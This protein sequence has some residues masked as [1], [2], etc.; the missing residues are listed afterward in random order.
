MRFH[1]RRCHPFV[2]LSKSA[3]PT[4]GDQIYAV[5]RM[6]KFFDHAL[7]VNEGRLGGATKKPRTL[8]IPSGLQGDLGMP[9]FTADGKVIGI[10]VLQIPSKEDVEGGD[11]TEMMGGGMSV[12]ILP[13]DEVVK[14]TKRSKEI[15]AKSDA[16][17]DKKPD[18]SKPAANGETK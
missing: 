13:A 16:A 15:A 1:L 14:A 8:L 9:M 10:G 4:V 2:D 18:E 6:A 7:T 3:S 12:M 11:M 17:G 5:D